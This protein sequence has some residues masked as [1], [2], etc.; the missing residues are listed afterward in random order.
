[1]S[2]RAAFSP[3][4]DLPFAE[5][6]DL[7]QILDL[8][9]GARDTVR[10]TFLSYTLRGR[11]GSYWDDLD[12]ALRRAAGRGAAVRVM[13][14]DWSTGEPKIDYLKSLHLA[15]EVEVR[16]VTI[17]EASEGFIPFARVIH[18]KFLTVDG[19]RFW[20]GTSNWE[21][22]Y[23]HASRNM[24]VVARHRRVAGELD[25]GFD[26]VWES[27]HAEPVDPARE[28]PRKRIAD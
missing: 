13:V 11:D 6:W 9:G 15:P 12:V 2:V 25:R 23:F 4:G 19:D 14:S 20:L 8:I 7:P 16:V 28:Y 21:K 17:P 5:D 22:S 26:A 10:V 1:V 3:A 27:V 18:A 24:G